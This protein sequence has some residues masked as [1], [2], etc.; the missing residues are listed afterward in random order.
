MT[1]STG[2]ARR[3]AWCAAGGGTLLVVAKTLSRGGGGG[4]CSVLPNIFVRDL[5][6]FASLLLLWPVL[7]AVEERV[8]LL[9]R[10]CVS[11]GSVSSMVVV[12]ELLDSLFL[13]VDI[14]VIVNSDLFFA[15][16]LLLAIEVFFVIDMGVS[17]VALVSWED[18]TNA[19]GPTDLGATFACLCVPWIWF[20]ILSNTAFNRLRF[21]CWL[22]LFCW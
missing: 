1:A 11:S 21:L 15:L 19:V 14:G 10:L 13:I 12:E 6:C 8:R 2:P 20:E 7:L 16:L 9:F 18:T 4:L 5:N 17:N 22:L 3:C